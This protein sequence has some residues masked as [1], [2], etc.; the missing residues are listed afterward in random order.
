MCSS[1]NHVSIA[2]SSTLYYNCLWVMP[3]SECHLSTFLYTDVWWALLWSV[4]CVWFLQLKINSAPVIMHFPAK[5]KPKKADTMDIHRCVYCIIL[6][7]CGV[8]YDY[9]VFAVE[10]WSTDDFFSMCSRCWC[11]EMVWPQIVIATIG[12]G[13]G[14][15]AGAI[16]PRFQVGGAEVSFCP[17]RFWASK[18]PIKRPSPLHNH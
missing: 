9:L 12:V 2:F 8:A 13:D 3:W 7:H 5:G 11:R 15:A 4:I 14:G 18:I 10:A 1:V 6:I 16:T 17:P